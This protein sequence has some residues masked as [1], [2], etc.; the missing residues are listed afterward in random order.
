MNL[1][2]NDISSN[3]A[4]QKRHSQA[5]PL[6]IA[7]KS[8]RYIARAQGSQVWDV[9]GNRYIDFTSGI[10]VLN[11][12][13][14]HPSVLCAIEQ[15]LGEYMHTCFQ[16]S[17]YEKYIELAERLNQLAPGEMQKKTA[18]FSTG[19]EAMENAVKIA[20]YTTGR[21]GVITFS[22]SFH[23]RT[24]L[25]LTM[26][27]K[28]KPYKTGFGPLAPAVYHTPFPNAYHGI[29]DQQAL[30]MLENLLKVSISPDEIAAI[31]VEPVQG[32]G[33]FNIASEFFMQALRKLCD[34]YGILL[35]ADEIQTAFGRTGT[36]FA[37]QHT[38][39]VPDLICTAKSL[40]GGLPIAAVTGTAQFMDQVPVGGLGTTFGGNPVACSAALA[41][42]DTLEQD[43]LLQRA[44]DIG[45]RIQNRLGQIQARDNVGSIGEIRGIGAMIAIEFVFNKDPQRPNPELVRNLMTHARNQGL[46]LL[47]AGKD[48]QVVRLLPALTIDWDVLDE[49]LDILDECISHLLSSQG[50]HSK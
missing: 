26:T 34:Q 13:H 11:L 30:D 50:N 29:S 14:R 4:L 20:R 32:E 46:L 22:G 43:S 38:G 31:V 1:L 48:A 41:V 7:C 27:G 33:G 6:A 19:A 8:D 39:L 3:Q 2:R 21:S 12:G 23:G 16:A 37:S 45:E 10:S 42:L 25:T 28:A 5:V 47:S 49:G 17:P 35:I 40:G 9:E 36:M 44:N 15:Q 24:L 18:L